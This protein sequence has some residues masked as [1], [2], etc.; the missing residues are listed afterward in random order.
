MGALTLG[1]L[2]AIGIQPA[3]LALSGVL[4]LGGALFLE[5]FAFSEKSGDLF[6]QAPR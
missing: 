4:A 6:R 3:T 2:A 5:T 1:I